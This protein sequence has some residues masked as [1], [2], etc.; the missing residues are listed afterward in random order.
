MKP[1]SVKKGLRESSSPRMWVAFFALAALLLTTCTK[2]DDTT[3]VLLGQEEY[4]EGIEAVM[5]FIPAPLQDSMSRHLGDI[6]SGPVPPNIEGSF[7]I[8]PKIRCCSNLPSEYWPLGI[9][10][11]DMGLRISD[12][13][14]GIATL[15]LYEASGT[16][17]ERVNVHGDGN[18]FSISYI[19][20]K[21]LSL[22]GITTIIRRGIIIMGEISE[23]GIHDLHFLT[24]VIDVSSDRDNGW[25]S[26]GQVYVY[27]D[28]DGLSYKESTLQTP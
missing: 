8:H 27:R 4:V 17:T 22:D 9:Q 12:Q 11:A 5:Q 7:L 13:H 24:V 2:N 3:L 15:E 26:P 19:E 10:E 18:K 21:P 28:G 6:P 23:E 14:N 1:S 16:T 25:T 20:N